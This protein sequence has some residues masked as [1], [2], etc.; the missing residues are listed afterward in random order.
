MQKLLRL[1]SSHLFTFVF[2]SITLGGGSWRNLW[3]MS[4]SV[5]PIFSSKSFIVSGLTFRSLIHFEFSFNTAS[6]FTVVSSVCVLSLFSCVWLFVMLWT[7][8]HQLL[9]P[10]DSP[11][12]STGMGCHALLQG[13]FLTWGLNLHLLQLLHCRQIPYHWATR[14]ALYHQYLVLIS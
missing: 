6:L 7:I 5:L 1:V 13:I 12:K 10:W 14:E 8:A 11:G 2:I 4:E 9:C 3:F